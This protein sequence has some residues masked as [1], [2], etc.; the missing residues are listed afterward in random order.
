MPLRARIIPR[1]LPNYSTS[2]TSQ[3]VK[4]NDEV[5]FAS[6]GAVRSATLN[7]PR[8]LNAITQNMCDLLINRLLEYGKSDLVGSIIIKGAGR[9]FSAGGDVA[10]VA[11]RSREEGI[12]NASDKNSEYFRVE[13]GLN[14]LIGTY[15]KPYVSFLDGFV[16]GGG[17]GLSAHGSFRVATEK[18]SFAMPEARIGYCPDVGGLFFLSRLNGQ[19]GLYAALTSHTVNGYDAYRMGIATHYVN[20]ELLPQVESRLAELEAGAIDLAEY[21]RLVD[22][23]IDDFASEPPADYK[24]AFSTTDLLII[25]ECFKKDTVEEIIDA[26]RANADKSPKFVA[27]TLQ[28]LESRSPLSLK[29]ILKAYRKNAK[30]D[31]KSALELDMVLCHNF[32]LNP[33]FTEGVTSLL[34]EKRSPNWS[35]ATLEEVTPD[36]VEKFFQP[37]SNHRP[38]KFENDITFKQYPYQFGLPS[39]QSVMDYVIGETSEEETKATRKDVLEHFKRKY[40]NGAKQ[41]LEEYLTELLDRRTTPDKEDPTLL[42][43]NY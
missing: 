35:P 11:L 37:T 33:N 40:P 24:P 17:V 3:P 9:A 7:R 31:F 28:A 22:E 5:L 1:M 6:N 29:V 36:M 26:L 16:M 27:E 18:T 43:W 15:K 39:E 41:G 42:D 23:S 38:V 21:Y 13:F 8:K 12:E 25:D 4:D 32:C 10:Q 34:I 30:L 14:H 2:S 20:S 19:F